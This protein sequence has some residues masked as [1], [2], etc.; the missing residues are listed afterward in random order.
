MNIAKF[1][2]D[3]EQKE[4]KYSPQEAALYTAMHI[5]QLG[6]PSLAEQLHD[7][8]SSPRAFSSYLVDDKT[9]LLNTLTAKAGAAVMDALSG[10]SKLHIEEITSYQKLYDSAANSAYIKFEFVSPTMFKKMVDMNLLPSPEN[11]FQHLAHRWRFYSEDVETFPN[12]E[13][14][15]IVVRSINLRTVKV[16]PTKVPFGHNAVLGKV[17]F[18]LPETLK[19]YWKYYHALASYANFSGIGSYT[20]QGC[21]QV[22][23]ENIA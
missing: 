1:K 15:S 3:W 9:L 21:G 5:F 14:S 20:A 18:K 2:I 12:L 11:I 6:N 7:D 17:V 4:T 19:S 16:H 13:F 23:Y 8:N 22:R 10:N